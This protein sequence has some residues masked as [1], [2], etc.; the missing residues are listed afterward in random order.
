MAIGTGR[1][2]SNPNRVGAAVD[3]VAAVTEEEEDDMMK[4]VDA[5]TTI[6]VQSTTYQ[7]QVPPSV[8]ILEIFSAVEL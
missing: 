4:T 3:D 8:T 5:V 2:N 1:L 6:K 7:A